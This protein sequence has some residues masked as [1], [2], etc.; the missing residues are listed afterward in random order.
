MQGT[1]T[2]SGEPLPERSTTGS[3][4]ERLE[5]GE[6][7]F[8]PSAPFPL[9]EGADRAFLLAQQIGGRAHKNICYNPASG[10]T[11]GFVWRSAEQAQRLQTVLATFSRAAAAWLAAALPRYRGACELDRA[12]FRPEEE[13][14]RRL[15]LNARNDLLHVDSFP[16]RPARGR[17]ILRLFANINPTEPRIW[18]TSEPL[19]LLLSRYGKRIER[20]GTGFWQQ[21]G[22]G[23]L[24]LFRPP[25]E[26]HCN[27]DLFMLR[28][29]DYLKRNTRFQQSGPRRLWKFP[30]G[31]AWLAMTDGCCHAELRGRFALEHSFFIAPRALVRPELAPA[32]LIRA[33]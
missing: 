26:R 9:P 5:C 13:A 25:Q 16:N 3:A 18:A 30:P 6:V 24:G 20:K 14:T 27:T 21:L 4:E 8:Y 32:A 28:L 29:H 2:P 19:P 31:S 10:E 17:R 23:V 7:L 22:V 12:S 1:H 33:A 15:R 11:T